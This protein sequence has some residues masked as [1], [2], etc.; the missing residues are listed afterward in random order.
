M[1]DMRRG[2]KLN[3]A[4]REVLENLLDVWY[5]KIDRRSALGGLTLGRHSHQQAHGSALEKCHLR[6]GRE[7]KRDPEGLTIKLNRAVEVLHGNQQLR[8]C[9]L[10]QVHFA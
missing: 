4:R 10:R 6:R 8:H 1:N 2:L 5:L 7:Q 3:S 9:G